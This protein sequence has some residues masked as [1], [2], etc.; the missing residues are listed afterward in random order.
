MIRMILAATFALTLTACGQEPPPPAPPP[1]PPEPLVDEP[2]PSAEDSVAARIE[3]LLEGTHRAEGHAA[4]DRYR[5]PRETLLFFGIRSDASVLEIAPGGGWYTEILAPLV[6]EEGRYIGALNDPD[7]AANERAQEYF[8]RTNQALRDKLAEHPDLYDHAE[9]IEI[10]PAAPVF[11]EEESVDLVLTFRNVHGWV[12]AGTAEATFK[13]AFDVLKPG[14]VLG[15]VQHRAASGAEYTGNGYVSEEQVIELASG[16]GFVYEH[17][18][19]INANPNDTKDHPNGV[20]TLPPVLRVGDEDPEKYLA[21]GES[22]RMTIR[23]V[24]PERSDEVIAD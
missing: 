3:A 24:K 23:F 17:S 2:V 1:A 22:D 10:D 9:L 11:G 16:A 6:R 12:G 13:A 19:E 18:S 14:G 5:N 15:V 20:W 8:A 21:I 4:R 7:K